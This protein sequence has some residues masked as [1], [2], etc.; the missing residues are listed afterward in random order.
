MTNEVTVTMP[1]ALTADMLRAVRLHPTTS[2]Q[3]KDEEHRRMGWLLC[4]WDVLVEHRFA[5]QDDRLQRCAACGEVFD[6]DD[7][8]E[9]DDDV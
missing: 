7:H 1:L 2:T 5:P 4:A 9:E 6:L 8:A 3:D